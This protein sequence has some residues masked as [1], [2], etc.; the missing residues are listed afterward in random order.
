MVT[1]GGVLT[2]VNGA[3]GKVLYRERLGAPGA[4]FASPVAA[5]G[6]LYLSSAE[7]VVTVIEDNPEKL[8]VL[9]KHD[10]KESIYATPAI[11]GNR[12]YIRTGQ[13]LYAFGE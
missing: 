8:K 12:I 10:F 11:A 9:A 4:Y 6:R 1:N 3:D 13:R 7:G 5:N 2:C